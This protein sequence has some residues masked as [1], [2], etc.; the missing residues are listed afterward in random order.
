M[1]NALIIS[2]TS[3]KN[4]SHETQTEALTRYCVENNFFVAGIMEIHYSAFKEGYA[5]RFMEDF[6]AVPLEC[7]DEELEHIIFWSGDRMCRNI[8]EFNLLVRKM[9]LIKNYTIHLALNGHQSKLFSLLNNPY[10][11]QSLNI[12]QE[13][14]VGEKLSSILSHKMKRSRELRLKRYKRLHETVRPYL[15][16]KVSYGKIVKKIKRSGRMIPI[17]I[18]SNHHHDIVDLINY[19][20]TKQNLTDNQIIKL[21]NSNRIFSKEML[22][23]IEQSFSWE[24][25]NLKMIA[26]QRTIR[27]PL[28]Y[29]EYLND[30]NDMTMQDL[31]QVNFIKNKIISRREYYLIRYSDGME[32]WIPSDQPVSEYIVRS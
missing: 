1:V 24:E 29:M 11:Q 23:G 25:R 4:Q 3:T 8:E 9:L 17:T 32:C 10:S 14:L 22:E 5:D 6:Q 26:F 13:V 30:M 7:D 27:P 20:R 28:R 19:L 2:R 12:V 21:L 31:H 18:T 16:G 15:G